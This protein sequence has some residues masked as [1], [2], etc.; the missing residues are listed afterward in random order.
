[1]KHRA[2]EIAWRDIDDARRLVDEKTQQLKAI[3]HLS[4]LVAGFAMVVM[5]EIQL[6]TNMS[7]VLLVM[8]GASTSM[9]V[10]LMLVAMINCTFI[11]TAILKYDCKRRDEP[12]EDFWRKRCEGDWKM[13]FKAFTC[14]VPC[15]LCVLAL[16]GWVAFYEQPGRNIAAGIVTFVATAC[17]SGWFLHTKAK[18]S[19]WLT[20]PTTRLM[21]ISR[22]D[23][24]GMGGGMGGHEDDHDPNGR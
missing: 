2:R 6:P 20:S 24:G 19:S 22:R 14:G 13:S 7:T 21:S 16:L 8:F 10:G 1:M 5:V 12:F 4:A 18:W 11:L 9:V 3:S 15:F 17:L 23:G